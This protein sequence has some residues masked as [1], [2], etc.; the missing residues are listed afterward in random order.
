MALLERMKHKQ[1]NESDKTLEDVED[2][3]DRALLE[4]PKPA[5][6]GKRTRDEMIAELKASR[7]GAGDLG[8][9]GGAGDGLEKVKKDPRFKPIAKLEA[10][11]SR[12]KE[13]EV[14]WKPVEGEKKRRKKK[15]VK[16]DDPSVPV[17]TPLAPPAALPLPIPVPT[18]DLDDDEFDIFGDAGDYKGLDTDS[19][20]D[21][22]LTAAKSKT[23]TSAPA[24]ST[25]TL[26]AKRSYFDDEDEESISLSTAPSAVTNLAATSARA[27]KNTAGGSDG[28]QEQDDGGEG[29]PMR[30][31]PLSGSA[32]PSVRDLLDLDAAQEKEEKRKEVRLLSTRAACVQQL[33]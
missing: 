10:G 28:E 18:I 24:P 9:P 22:A 30:L 23:P 25:T 26:P 33:D 13:K 8:V 15:R 11:V 14:G 21:D 2:E 7:S 29:R 1:A 20:D 4:K 32:I 19:D 3:L 5:K 17:N 27:S 16:V 6:G 31:Q 12:A